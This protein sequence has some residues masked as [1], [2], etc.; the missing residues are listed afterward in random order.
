MNAVG[1]SNG[2]SSTVGYNV[3]TA[4]AGAVTSTAT[5]V[6]SGASSG[7]SAALAGIGKAAPNFGNRI[8]AVGAS[9]IQPFTG[10]PPGGTDPTTT[11]KAGAA[12][13]SSALNGLNGAF[14]AMGGA[15]DKAMAAMKGKSG[16]NTATAAAGKASGCGPGGCPNAQAST[17][18]ADTSVAKADS[19]GKDSQTSTPAWEMAKAE[20]AP[21]TTPDPANQ[22]IDPASE[23][24]LGSNP[25]G[26]SYAYEPPVI[27]DEPIEENSLG[28]GETMDTA[29]T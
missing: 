26:Q 15:I 4:V 12:A 8:A 5:A 20:P 25:P 23:T 7:A 13:L 1:P 9:A 11:N 29:I 6:A 16:G 18:K 3:L 14:D 2:A 17:G 28:G 19:T 10:A 24:G 27:P 22:A 21:V